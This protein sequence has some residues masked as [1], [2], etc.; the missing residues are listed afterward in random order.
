MQTKPIKVSPKSFQE[1]TLLSEATKWT[2]GEVVDWLI[3]LAKQS[4]H[5]GV[6][7]IRTLQPA[8]DADPISV[9]V[10]DE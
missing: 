4:K 7:E 10:V 8:P 2:K 5:Y 1:I 3:G 9:Y 6:I